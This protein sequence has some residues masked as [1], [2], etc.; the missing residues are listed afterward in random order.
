MLGSY[1]DAVEGPLLFMVDPS[2]LSWVS[3]NDDCEKVLF[4][5]SYRVTRG[6]PLGRPSNQLKQNWRS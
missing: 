2:G 6:W 5:L 4:L 3:C 1:D